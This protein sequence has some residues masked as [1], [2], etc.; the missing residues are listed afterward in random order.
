MK[1]FYDKTPLYYGVLTQWLVLLL[2]I[3]LSLQV[4]A[5]EYLVASPTQYQQAL[6]QLQPGDKIILKNGIWQDFEIEFTA[7]GRAD[8]LIELTA[9]T[10]GEVILSGQSNLT[11]AGE[12]LKVSGL[13]FKDG[14]T[15][16]NEVI[17]FKKSDKEVANHS[18]VTEVVIDN[19]NNPD[20]HISDNW[21][22]LYGQHNRLDH[23]HFAAK[24]NAGVTL[25]VRLEG[26]HNQQNQHSI[27]HNYFG[28]R[29]ILGSNGGETI[30][31][32]TSHHSLS[33]SLT[34]IEN[35][36]FD[37]CDGEVE[38]ISV[39]SGKNRIQNNLFYQSRGTL[40]LRHG[41]GNIIDSNVFLGNGV[42][43]TGGIRIINR[44][45][46]VTNNY[47]EGLTG[48]RFGSGFTMMN[49]VP[50]SPINRYHQVVNANVHHNSFINLDHIELAAGSD[51]ERSAAPKDSTI[52][53]NLFINPQSPLAYHDDISGLRF[54][55]NITNF[56]SKDLNPIIKK[57]MSTHNITMARAANGLL[58]PSDVKL[59]Q[60]GA[61]SALLPITKQQTGTTWYPKSEIS[62][63][64]QSGNTISVNAKASELEHAVTASQPGDTLLLNDG[65]YNIDTILAID[66][67][68]TLKA[69]NKHQAVVS[70]K[71]SSLFE[72]QN[73]GNLQLDGLRITG[74]NSP[75][76][77]GNS[78]IR[79]RSTGMLTNYRFEMINSIIEQLNT[80][81]QFH[82]FDSG[83][84]AFADEITITHNLF[85]HISGD[86]F[87]LD[88]ET[89]DKGIYNAEY[90]TLSHNQFEHIQ[91]TVASVYRG[92]SDESTFGPH[93]LVKH[94]QFNDV[95]MG[96]NN[97][98]GALLK[99][100]GVQVSQIDNN[101]FSDSAAIIIEHTVGEPKTRIA[102]NQ[103][104]NSAPPQVNE[105]VATGKHTANIN[106]NKVQ[107]K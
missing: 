18:R 33:D 79:T 86:L 77:N 81:H 2:L 69:L 100:H 49:G 39:K 99:L 27:D 13:V 63:A 92:G 14:F 85:S 16:S 42:E 17:S 80:H 61:S 107:T 6:K 106:N 58:Y 67:T 8:A 28:P 12:Y 24:R 41:N 56:A 5:Q 51:S 76:A 105:L 73:N 34:V 25:A 88:K 60:Y 20:R 47:L 103:L 15:P 71:H 32:G 64:F 44:D 23:N 53:Q 30:R 19:Y 10:K 31:I 101:H 87:R 55:D 1:P 93:V 29:P 66:K 65:Q 4:N 84:R 21:I 96:K 70:F 26:E 91:G 83:K 11:L 78:V 54:S 94:N 48:T 75:N 97:L 50:N 104:N 98:S 102:N 9:Q 38:I 95:A 45:Q 43:H 7:T 72:I 62:V 89:D 52:T 57:G 68:L 90:L 74:I 22:G 46:V 37:R 59:A 35:N 40:T 3:T 36:Y 82:F